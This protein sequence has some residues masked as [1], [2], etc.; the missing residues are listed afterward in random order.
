MGIVLIFDDNVSRDGE[1]TGLF[2]MHGRYDVPIV[3]AFFLGED[4][5]SR[6]SGSGWNS[7][8]RMRRMGKVVIVADIARMLPVRL[9]KLHEGGLKESL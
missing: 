8:E 2:R 3:L 6:L 1:S 5:F 7:P 9:Q 4:L